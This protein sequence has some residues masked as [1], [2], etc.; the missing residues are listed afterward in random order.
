VIQVNARTLA[1]DNNFRNNSIR[2]RILNTDSYEFITFTPTSLEGLPDSVAAGD[3]VTF[4]MIG[5]LTIRDVTNE[6]TFEVEATA[7]SAT[8]ISGTASTIIGREAFNLIIPTVPNVANV[9][10]EV[11]LY[12]DFVANAVEG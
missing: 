3:T 4:S 9:E 2:N 12:I 6:V 11:E 5:D 8:Q 7:V 10:E 1:T